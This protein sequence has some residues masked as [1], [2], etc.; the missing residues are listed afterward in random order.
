M[1][2]KR[3]KATKPLAKKSIVP[4]DTLYERVRDW[5]DKNYTAVIGAGAAF[6]V[7]ILA[8]W[9]FG[10]Y[11]NSRQVR[12]ETEYGMLAAK[13]PAEGK[14]SPADWEK[15]IPDLQKFI[16]EHK[17]SNL[18]LNAR[19]ELAKAYYETKRYDDAVKTGSEALNAVPAGH[20][21]KP[22]VE[23][24]LA[25][26]YQ[27]SGKTDQAAQEW[28][29]LKNL[30]LPEFEREAAWNLGRIYA[31]KKDTAKA[32]EMFELAAKAPGEYPPHALLNQEL[33]KAKTE[34]GGTGQASA[35][36]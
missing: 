28:T 8:S 27:A 17:S 10:A 20:G 32:L 16:T 7:I 15:I 29:N 2:A 11:E 31:A 9:G 34:A 19:I 36:Q 23:Y 6:I 3:A 4:Q 24:Q 33:A 30:G 26:A 18:A 12:M 21:L 5:V 14:G 22:L 13:F 35:K 25:Y 1:G